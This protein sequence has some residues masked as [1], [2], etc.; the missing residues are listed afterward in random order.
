[1][2]SHQRLSKQELKR[3]PAFNVFL[4]SV[5]NRLE[6]L[7]G[8]LLKVGAG[9]LIAI[10][11]IGGIY[12]FYSYNRSKAQTAFAKALDLFNA[13]VKDPKDVPSG[14]IVKRYF[15]DEQ[16]KYKEAASAFET[17]AQYSSQRELSRY[18]EALCFLKTDVPQGQAKLKT[19]AEGT[20]QVSQMAR[21]AL[22]QSLESTGQADNA[23]ELYKQLLDIWEKT[24]G[25]GVIVSPQV[26]QLS[27]GR[28]Y[29]A[30][31]STAEASQCYV[32]TIGLARSSRVA[33][34][35]YER[36]SKVDPETARKIQPPKLT[37]E[38]PA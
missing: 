30:K 27:M 38:D 14:P 18:Y 4:R 11:A 16:Q 1:M 36:L 21:L 9:V 23:I 25:D 7:G 20:G 28:I 26:V 35:A 19:L 13:E 2:A 33:I 15:T 31:G 17:A 37:D 24:K 12:A 3:E 10:V 5:Q 8:N 22:A 32:K 6:H 34:E 29:E